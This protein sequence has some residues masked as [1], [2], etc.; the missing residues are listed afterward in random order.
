MPPIER[1]SY[2]EQTLHQCRFSSF[3]HWL[4]LLCKAPPLTANW[5]TLKGSRQ[6]AVF[7][8][9]FFSHLCS[10]G[11]WWFRVISRKYK[12][13]K[14]LHRA[15]KRGLQT[16][17]YTVTLCIRVYDFVCAWAGIVYV[18]SWLWEIGNSHWTAL[19]ECLSYHISSFVPNVHVLFVDSDIDFV[20]VQCKNKKPL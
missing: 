12:R 14:A 11:P 1:S 13:S 2:E 6:E 4:V 10:P 15:S 18:P 19:G 8:L 3:L 16:W 20:S 5:L 17:S 7:V 9:C